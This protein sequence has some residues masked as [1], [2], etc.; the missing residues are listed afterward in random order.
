MSTHLSRDKLSS[1]VW[2]NSG[3]VKQQMGEKKA[4]RIS[5][6]NSRRTVI[7]VVINLIVA[8]PSPSLCSLNFLGVIKHTVYSFYHIIS[9]W[10]VGWK[11]VESNW[12]IILQHPFLFVV[13]RR[14]SRVKIYFICSRHFNTRL[15]WV[16]FCQHS[17]VFALIKLCFDCQFAAEYVI[18]ADLGEAEMFLCGKQQHNARNLP[19]KFKRCECSLHI[20]PLARRKRKRQGKKNTRKNIISDLM[21]TAF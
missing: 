7:H 2:W 9:C 3:E 10:W 21:L 12:I 11:G 15:N 16:I 19:I 5:S 17:V 6:H 20:D 1:V 14:I 13:F 4:H 8:S 18:K